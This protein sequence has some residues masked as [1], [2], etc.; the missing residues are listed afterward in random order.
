MKVAKAILRN[1][2]SLNEVTNP[3]NET[4]VRATKKI[5]HPKLL[6]ITETPRCGFGLGARTKWLTS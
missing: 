2:S 6:Q 4:F 3:I 1:D 5:A